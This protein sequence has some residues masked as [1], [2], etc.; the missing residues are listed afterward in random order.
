MKKRRVN[1]SGVFPFTQGRCSQFPESFIEYIKDFSESITTKDDIARPL[2]LRVARPGD[3]HL[4]KSVL[5]AYGHSMSNYKNLEF[6]PEDKIDL[7]IH[8]ITH[9]LEHRFF[10]NF[11]VIYKDHLLDYPIAFLQIDPY[12]LSSISN[13]F[14]TVLLPQWNVFLKHPLTENHL[15]GIDLLELSRFLQTNFDAVKLRGYIASLKRGYSLQHRCEEG[16]MQFV[17]DSFYCLHN[18]QG[19]LSADQLAC[20]VSYGILPQFQ[21]QGIMTQAWSKL[22]ARLKGTVVKFLFSDRVAVPNKASVRLLRHQG[23]QTC[24]LYQTYYSSEYRTRC[25]PSG[26]FSESCVA[27]SCCLDV[28]YKTKIKKKAPCLLSA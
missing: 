22:I 9:C 12:N 1:G 25:H 8:N 15:N 2:Q 19:H 13:N 23:F 11:L 17:I 14:K 26:D 5:D 10:V 16:W 6:F 27:L 7:I 28:P 4:I 24:A 21:H 18:L 20:N 3:A